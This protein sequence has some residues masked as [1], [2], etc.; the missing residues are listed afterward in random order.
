MTMSECWFDFARRIE[1]AN[2]AAMIKVVREMQSRWGWALAQALQ[3]ACESEQAKAVLQNATSKTSISLRRGV[4]PRSMI[5]DNCGGDD[6]SS[7]KQ[8]GEIQRGTV[9][10]PQR[11][12]FSS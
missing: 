4:S 2:D 12:A 7:M 11:S 1:A 5:E 10:T 9:L 6:V 3:P 8:E